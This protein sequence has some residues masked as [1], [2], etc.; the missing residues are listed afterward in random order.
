MLIFFLEEN[1]EDT[2]IFFLWKEDSFRQ[3]NIIYFFLKENEDNFFYL[4]IRFPQ[5]Q[6]QK[7]L[8][9]KDLFLNLL[10][11]TYDFFLRRK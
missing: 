2:H 1:T 5:K 7:T 10:I 9:N 3:S 4:P 11:P 8:I 6:K